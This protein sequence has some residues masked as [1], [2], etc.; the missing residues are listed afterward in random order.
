MPAGSSRNPRPKGEGG[1]RRSSTD[2]GGFRGT[3]GQGR[4]GSTPGRGSGEGGSGR[5]GKPVGRGKP[6]GTGASQGRDGGKRDGGPRDGGSRSGG[7]RGQR[8]TQPQGGSPAPRRKGPGPSKGREHVERPPLPDDRPPLPRGLRREITKVVGDGRKADEVQTAVAVGLER[9]DADD[10]RGALTY[11]QWAR[12]VAGNSGSIR[13]V[14]GVALYLDG[15]FGASRKE[16]QAY[17]RMTE[18]QDQNHLIAD[19]LRALD[20]DLEQIP[21]LVE[22]MGDA[23]L[24]AQLE[25]RIVW[26]SHVADQGDPLAA[27]AVLAP[28]VAALD[29]PAAADLESEVAARVWYVAGDL[30]DR[31]GRD[32]EAA[33]WFR[34]VVETGDEWDAAERLDRLG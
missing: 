5:S 14:L 18:R 22:A 10:P 25:G 24:D 6:S 7:P 21:D 28:A 16:L 31:A 9:I 32:K 27:I 15:Q 29:T 34:R 8:G 26:A 2:S 4:K 1:K 12:H 23:P 3:G 33:R 19:C 17:R 30:A 13:E 20:Q 11:L